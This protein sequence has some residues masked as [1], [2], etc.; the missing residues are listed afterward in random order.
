[1][2]AAYTRAAAVAVISGRR[3]NAALRPAEF[4][5]IVLENAMAHQAATL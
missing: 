2:A 1:M 3:R 5:C 4:P